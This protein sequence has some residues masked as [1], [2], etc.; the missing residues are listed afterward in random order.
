MAE[1]QA[2][3]RPGRPCAARP[4]IDDWPRLLDLYRT[5]SLRVRCLAAPALGRLR[6]RSSRSL[7]GGATPP[8]GLRLPVTL[9][10]SSMPGIRDNAGA[11]E[12]QGG[13][14]ASLQAKVRTLAEHAGGA[15][16]QVLVTQGPENLGTATFKI[17]GA[18]HMTPYM[19]AIGP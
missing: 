15:L 4:L 19:V 3:S 6:G 13:P 14:A 17:V 12:L 10:V 9:S 11:A 2:A 8:A 16:T 5:V 7:C 1:S 18:P